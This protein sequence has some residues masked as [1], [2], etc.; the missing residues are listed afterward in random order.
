MRAF[1]GLGFWG[2]LFH[3]FRMGGRNWEFI[4]LSATLPLV[5][6]LA[7]AQT[8]PD[9]GTI[10]QQIEQ[11]RALPQ[12]PAAPRRAAPPPEIRPPAGLSVFVKSF[13]FAGNT[14]VDAESLT[15][16]VAPFV[17]QTLDFAGLQRAADAVARVYREAGWIVRVYLPEQDVTEGVITLH[18]LEALFGGVRFEGEAPQKVSREQIEAFFK[19]RQR[20]GEPLSADSLDRALLLSD[21]LPGVSIAGTLAPGQSDAQTALVLQTTDEPDVYGDVTI[22]N[23]G[24]RSTGSDRLAA[25]VNFN[26]PFGAGDLVSVNALRTRGSEYGRLA[27]TVPVGADGLRIGVNASTLNYRVVEGLGAQAEVPIRGGSDGVG[28]DLTYPIHRAR[29]SNLYFSAGADRKS[30]LNQDA[31]IRSDYNTESLRVGLSANLFDNVGGGGANSASVQWVVGRLAHVLAH[32]Q[33]ETLPRKYEK[34]VY[35]I[36]RQ[37]AITEEHSVFVSLS[38][39]HALQG[40]DSSEKFFIGGSTSVRAYPVSE[41]GGERGQVLTGEWRWRV[42]PELSISGFIDLGKVV[43]LPATASDRERG[44]LLHGKGVAVAWQAP[45]GI[46]PRL[47]WARRDGAHPQPTPAGTDGDGTI[48]LDRYWLSLTK[49]F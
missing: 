21:D 11:P 13:R 43:V 28:L 34:V 2:A 29:L 48:K 44:M 9:A 4:S 26:S 38:G 7:T 14:L 41:L 6:S 12:M 3:R 33:I 25:N 30:F 5:C 15:A 20:V 47:T 40:L 46:T 10:R 8:L 19:S 37:Q 17:N 42:L 45:Y 24:S 31:L 1:V 22:D 16:A 49:T 35:G 27:L 39:Q 36:S 23:T 32:T 18:V